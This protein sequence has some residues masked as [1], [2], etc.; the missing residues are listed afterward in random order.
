MLDD[1]QFQARDSI[2]TLPHPSLG[3]FPMQNITPRFLGTP[4]TV[5]WIGPKLG[6]HT[7]E[8]LTQQLGFAPEKIDGLGQNG[9]I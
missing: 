2:V 7:A 5:T 8:V 1:P 4:A 9:V 3:D 6:Q